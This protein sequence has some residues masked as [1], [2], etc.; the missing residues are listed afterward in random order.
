MRNVTRARGRS[1]LRTRPK[2]KQDN[3][4]SREN[5]LLLER[6]LNQE[7]DE[8]C[9]EKMY[10]SIFHRTFQKVH[11][12]SYSTSSEGGDRS[13]VIEHIW[14]CRQMFRA[15]LNATE[16]LRL[17]LVSFPLE[18]RHEAAH[19]YYTRLD[20]RYVEPWNNHGKVWD[21]DRHDEPARGSDGPTTDIRVQH[22]KERGLS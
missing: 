14:R 5:E 22:H 19:V 13:V 8:R 1:G 20:G 4:V 16:G 10:E 18:S 9:R 17:Q 3:E 12:Y 11:I 15:A 6:E 21:L 7:S 2:L